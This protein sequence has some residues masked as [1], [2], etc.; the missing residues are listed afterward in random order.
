MNRVPRVA[1]VGRTNVGKSSLVNAL[2][3]R[4]V[5]I[6]KD[7]PGVTR[8]RNYAMVTRYEI[9]FELIDTGGVAGE[10]DQTLEESVKMQTFIAMQ[11]SDLIVAVFDG[12]HGVHPL[13]QEVVNL[14]RREDK[15]VLWV[16]NK[17]ER[18]GT[19]ITS[20]DF[21][22]L[23]IQEMLCVS[24][25]HRINIDILA[26]KILAQLGSTTIRDMNAVEP[27]RVA[28]VGRP[29]V[30]KSTFIN[31]VLGE[32]RLITAPIAGTTRDAIDVNLTR[33]GQ[34]YVL[35]DT[36]GL[37]KRPRVA[38]DTVERFS[39]LRTLRAIA[40]S[41]VVVLV[42]DATQG[43]PSEQEAKIAGLV[44]NR[45]KGLIVAVNKWDAIEKDHRTVRSYEDLVYEQLKFARYAP[46]LFI[47]A[48]TG[49]RCPSVL[50]MAKEVVTASSTR[51]P[52]A[53]LNRVFE[54]AFHRRPAPIY[55]GQSIKLFFAVQTATQPPTM[56]LF[57]TAPDKV[58]YSYQRYLKNAL[59]KEF[60]FPGVDIK[61]I[62]RKRS[63]KEDR[64]EA[65]G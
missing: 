12:L 33:E 38:D 63:S 41:D 65:H 40:R 3:G 34:E 16:I 59:R 56:V 10:Q 9:P 45:G 7:L 28:V 44:H 21:Y 15:P 54:N 26:K 11:E 48:L 60:P 46:V 39:N 49:R 36:A 18:P 29:N 43:A 4:R 13:D 22:A 64:V 37:R 24:T 32:D 62:F 5:A 35:I 6:V 2:M 57:V 25:A 42:I 55:H 52:T 20:A 50:Q 58:N 30:G 8:D 27:L 1:I 61:L 14:L 51:I 19:E 47:S 53:D 17:C 23:G 31:K